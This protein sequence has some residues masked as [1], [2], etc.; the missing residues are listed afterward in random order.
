MPIKC[1]NCVLAFI[2]MLDE[3]CRFRWCRLCWV[4][5]VGVWD[6]YVSCPKCGFRNF[7]KKALISQE[8]LFG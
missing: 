1:A 2:C 7:R 5:M 3:V 6:R 4:P 8:V